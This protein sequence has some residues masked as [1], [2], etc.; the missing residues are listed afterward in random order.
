[1]IAQTSREKG[2]SRIGSRFDDRRD[3]DQRG[4]HL[5]GNFGDG[6]ANLTVARPHDPSARADAIPLGNCALRFELGAE[7]GFLRLE[8]CIER[9]L[10]VT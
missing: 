6:T 1:M 3:H 5:P 4:I 9:Q 2:R 7:R 8:V 10:P